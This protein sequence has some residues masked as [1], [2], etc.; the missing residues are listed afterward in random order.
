MSWKIV[1]RKFSALKYEKGSPKRNQLNKSSLTS[2]FARKK[3]W[4]VLDDK[5]K[6][7]KS[8]ENI[9]DCNNFIKNPDNYKPSKKIKKYTKDMF[10]NS[11]NYFSKKRKN[12]KD[13]L[14][15]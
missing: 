4:L 10:R 14:N 8:F 3:V 1:R 13:S 11:R 2:E 9:K 6:P 12:L 7:L 5:N 15:Y